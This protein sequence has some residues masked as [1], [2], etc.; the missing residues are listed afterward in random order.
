MQASC[1]SSPSEGHARYNASVMP[2]PF[3]SKVLRL[4]RQIPKGKV[5]TYGQIAALAGNPRAARQVAW[6]LYSA[7]DKYGLPWQRVIGA[8]GWISLPQGKGQRLQKKL[9]QQEG[10]QVQRGGQIHLNVYQWKP[11]R[12]RLKGSEELSPQE[13]DEL[14]K[15]T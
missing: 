10:V 13:R 6:L 12:R 8:R 4:I 11:D 14:E 5:A 2:S 7:S 15:Y 9:L 3:S 1:E